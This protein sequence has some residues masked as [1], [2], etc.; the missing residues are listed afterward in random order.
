MPWPYA[1][2]LIK[3][4]AQEQCTQEVLT[5]SLETTEYHTSLNI[6]TVPTHQ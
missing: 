3:A 6:F 1:C 4:R 5:P 2:R